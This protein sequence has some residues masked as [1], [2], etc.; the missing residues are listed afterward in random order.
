MPFSRDDARYAPRAAGRLTFITAADEVGPRSGLCRKPPYDFAA[1]E[2][3]IISAGHDARTLPPSTILLAIT[4]MRD[5]SP[6]SHEKS[7]RYY[8]PTFAG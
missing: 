5:I 2:A 8:M 4:A 1:T 6:Y 7:A 3:A